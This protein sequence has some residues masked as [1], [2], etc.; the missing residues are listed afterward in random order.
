MGRTPKAILKRQEEADQRRREE[1][2]QRAGH[3]WRIDYGRFRYCERCYHSS[4]LSEK[5]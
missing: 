2:C 1:E 5:G 3:V 4:D